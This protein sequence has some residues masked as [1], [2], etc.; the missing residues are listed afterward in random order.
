L[1]QLFSEIFR[2]A[3][4]RTRFRSAGA[5]GA[6]TGYALGELLSLLRRF[7]L[8]VHG[9]QR[10]QIADAAAEC[11][12][13]VARH[14]GNGVPPIRNGQHPSVLL[15]VRMRNAAFAVVLLGMITK[16][17]VVFH[18][19][20]SFNETDALPKQATAF[21]LA[22]SFK[23]LLTRGEY[24]PRPLLEASAHVLPLP[25]CRALSKGFYGLSGWFTADIS[26]LT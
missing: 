20:S 8:L 6:V 22:L 24:R 18:L 17:A 15:V 12:L 5:W 19:D 26:G 25:K 11:D 2:T 4:K 23:P 7:R 1:Q 10:P 9:W 16:C 13:A 3:R 21:A 14:A